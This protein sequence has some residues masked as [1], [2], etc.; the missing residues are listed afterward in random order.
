LQANCSDETEGNISLYEARKEKKDLLEK[1]KPSPAL[2]ANVAQELAVLGRT[3]LQENLNEVLNAVS[4]AGRLLQSMPKIG[5][6]PAHM[7]MMN[8]DLTEPVE[9]DFDEFEEEEEFFEE[10]LP[11]DA[12]TIDLA[13]AALGGQYYRNNGNYQG[14]N[15]GYPRNYQNDNRGSQNFNRGQNSYGRNYDHNRSRNNDYNG[16]RNKDPNGSRNNDYNGSRNNDASGSRNNDF[17]RSRNNDFGN[18]KGDR[19]NKGDRNQQRNNGK[20][21]RSQNSYGNYQGKGASS[22]SRPD[23][24]PLKEILKTHESRFVEIDKKVQTMGEKVQKVETS[25]DGLKKDVTDGF[26]EVISLITPQ[27]ESKTPK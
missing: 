13:F 25:V 26:S 10:E 14:D 3:P 9:E 8:C 15:R 7:A 1:L 5:G 18:A 23:F 16:S 11:E 24:V 12:D 2:L 27:S 20:G 6:I 4:R 17:N 19:N 21:D 22:S